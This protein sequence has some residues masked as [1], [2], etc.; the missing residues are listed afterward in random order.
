LAFSV[1]AHLDPEILIID[2]VLAVGD[3]AFQQKCLGKI[4]DAARHGRTIL[5]VSHN[6]AA[7]RSLCHRVL[8]LDAGRV[9][10]DGD[11]DACIARYLRR[12]SE[13]GSNRVDV[14][15]IHRPHGHGGLTFQGIEL[16]AA[17]NHALLAAGTRIDVQLDLRVETVVSDVELS[18]AIDTPDG[19]RVCECRSSFTLG[20]IARLE[21]GTY[22]L[23]CGIDQNILNPGRYL[24]SVIA[25]SG[26]RVIDAVLRALPFEIEP[27]R[28]G[29]HE[30]V[31]LPGLIRLS[32]TW[33]APAPAG[34]H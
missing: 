22:R 2:E 29:A 20:R 24:L 16:C 32:S 27:A 14:S 30:R 13:P 34:D 5:F 12:A 21:P 9:V 10:M 23:N 4:G 3:A 31:D 19:V 6:M 33:T 11:V 8:L 25:R 18:V 26:S 7:V 28:T 15:A 17:G 1:A